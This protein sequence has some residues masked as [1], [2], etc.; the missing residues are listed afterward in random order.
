[1]VYYD[2]TDQGYEATI[3]KRIEYWNGRRNRGTAD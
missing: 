2:P 3:R 1:M